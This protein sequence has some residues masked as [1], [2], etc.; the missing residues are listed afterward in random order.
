MWAT[1]T[2]PSG[3]LV[4]RKFKPILPRGR[5]A[6]E[7]EI[8]GDAR[9]HNPEGKELWSQAH[10]Q[11]VSGDSA[12][13]QGHDPPGSSYGKGERTINRRTGAHHGLREVLDKL[14]KRGVFQ[15]FEHSVFHFFFIVHII[16]LMATKLVLCNNLQIGMKMQNGVYT[17]NTQKRTRSG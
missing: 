16:S 5:Q 1:V 3:S 14:S 6:E 15:H 7:G 17:T 4:S 11:V 12:C 13:L 8:R 10:S 2:W 9:G